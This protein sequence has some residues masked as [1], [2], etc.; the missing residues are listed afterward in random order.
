MKKYTVLILIFGLMLGLSGCIYTNVE[1]PGV[2]QTGTVFQLARDDFEIL[3]RVNVS[4]ETT[5]WFGAVLTGGTG[6]QALLEEARK[7]GGDEVMH[8]SFDLEQ[9]AVFFLIYNRVKWKATGIAVKLN[10]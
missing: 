10:K 2:V 3:D 9:Q 7:I 4:G 6:Y 5:L 8:Y 1:S